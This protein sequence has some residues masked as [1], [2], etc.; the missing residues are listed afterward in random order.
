MSISRTNAENPSAP[1]YGRGYKIDNNAGCPC[2]IIIENEAAC[3]TIVQRLTR[4]DQSEELIS[5]KECMPCD[6]PAA[7][8]CGGT[9]EDT[10]C[11]P[12]V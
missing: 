12:P 3:K 6:I 10:S 8:A 5:E 11:S 9:V 7:G 4:Y 1:E 2:R